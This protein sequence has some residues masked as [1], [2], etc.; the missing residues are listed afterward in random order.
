MCSEPLCIKLACV[1]SV[2]KGRGRELGRETTR[3]R[4]LAPNFP[5]PLPLITRATQ[6]SIKWASL[7]FLTASPLLR[8]L[9]YAGF[10]YLMLFFSALSSSDIPQLK[11]SS[12]KVTSKYASIVGHPVSPAPTR[13]PTVVVAAVLI[14]AFITALV[15]TLIHLV[16]KRY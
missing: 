4:A 12:T 5:H 2:R 8:T 14:A 15:I 1:A 13:V 10:I 6:A 7:A 9:I 3:E 16:R 11:D